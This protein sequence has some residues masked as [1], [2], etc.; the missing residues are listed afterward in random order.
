MMEEHGRLLFIF[1]KISRE[2]IVVKKEKKNPVIH[3]N[4]PHE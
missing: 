4:S 3:E 2:F 1:T